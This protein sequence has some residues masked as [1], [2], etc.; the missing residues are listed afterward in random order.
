M[1]RIVHA[2]NGS[3]VKYNRCRLA[4]EAQILSNLIVSALNKSA[5]S[6][7]NG[8]AAVFGNAGSKS[9]GVL[10]CNADINKLTARLIA[11][12]LSKPMEVGTA[13]VIATTFLS[14]AILSSKNSA[15]I[16]L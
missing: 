11:R 5:V 6:A 14:F 12:A 13:E 3:A 16:S 2:E 8:L 7:V 10:L 1:A 4:V 15:V 9:N